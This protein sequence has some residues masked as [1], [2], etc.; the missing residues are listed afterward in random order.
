MIKN[1]DIVCF[2]FTDWGQEM[3]SNRFHILTRFAK[4]NRVFLFQNPQYRSYFKFFFGCL[5]LDSVHKKDGLYLISPFLSISEPL[6]RLIYCTFVN[7][8]FKKYKINQPIFWFYNYNFYYLID[9]FRPKISCYHCTEDYVQSTKLLPVYEKNLPKVE[10]AENNL[11]KR[12]DLVFAV[13]EYLGKRLSEINPKTYLAFNA[14]DYDFYRSSQG[15]KKGKFGGKPVLGYCGNL[16]AKMNYKLLFCL[17][18]EI[19]CA[20]ILGGPVVCGN[21]YIEKLKK[22][23]N[24][25]FLGQLPVKALPELYREF[26]VCLIPYIQDDWF[27]KASQPLKLYEY[28][29]SGKPIVSTK[30]DCLRKV[31]GLVY[32]AKTIEEFI[33]KTKIALKENNLKLRLKRIELAKQNTWDDRFTIINQKMEEILAL[34]YDATKENEK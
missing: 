30:M 17:A 12:V 21:P 14:V 16:S 2:S 9:K 13:S 6:N 3:V 11:L 31:K 4:H 18:T 15:K 5:G 20:L 19:D 7:Y 24:V 29:A 22:M 32:E 27:V 33:A 26:D 28:M 8:I 10:E 34:K 25:K 23:S 1:K